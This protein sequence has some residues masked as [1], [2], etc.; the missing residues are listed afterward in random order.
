M[1]VGIID[2]NKYNVVT[3]NE[4]GDEL[5]QAAYND[6]RTAMSRARRF[7]REYPIVKVIPPTKTADK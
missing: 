6:A 3:V 7:R 4:L 1:Q 2:P 5:V